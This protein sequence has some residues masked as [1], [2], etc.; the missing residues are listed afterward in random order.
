MKSLYRRQRP[1]HILGFVAPLSRLM[2]PNW[3]GFVAYRSKIS[4][5]FARLKVRNRHLFCAFG[6][7]ISMNIRG[8]VA[9]I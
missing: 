7:K 1:L 5:T 4:T 8:F 3:H 2:K 9:C 6:L